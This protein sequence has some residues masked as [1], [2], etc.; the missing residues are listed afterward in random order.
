MA[1]RSLQDLPD[2]VI[3]TILGYV[4]APAAISLSATCRRY[5]NIANEPLLWKTY[6]QNNF[7]YWSASHKRKEK[8]R[9]AACD[10][11]KALYISRAAA[12]RPTRHLINRIIDKSTSQIDTLSN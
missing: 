12:P 7:R 2:E 4:P 10:D 5:H 6:C 11:W 9:D 3:E 8:L 1:P